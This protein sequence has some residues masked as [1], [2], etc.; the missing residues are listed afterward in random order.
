MHNRL[1]MLRAERR[2][3][4]REL[5]NAVDV[6]Y[7]T[8]G[9]IERGE[10]APSLHL[11]FRIARYFDLPIEAIFSPEEFAPLGSDALLPAA[12]GD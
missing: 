7:Q 12:P 6:H 10:Y 11:A 2:I 1:E 3:S 8:V 9:Y 5:A 4:R